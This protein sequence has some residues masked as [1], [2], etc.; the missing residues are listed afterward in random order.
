MQ[1]QYPF[2]KP[3]CYNLDGII[4]VGSGHTYYCE[5]GFG[6]SR[7]EGN[8]RSYLETKVEE[9]GSLEDINRRG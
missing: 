2:R 8:G 6:V 9:S 5:F 3:T 7:S 4:R 1:D